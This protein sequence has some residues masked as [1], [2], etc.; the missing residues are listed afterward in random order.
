MDELIVHR[1]TAAKYL[2]ELVRIG[3]LTRHKIGKENYYLNDALYVLLQN[4]GAKL[5]AKP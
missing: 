5:E 1:N 4:V 3:L 2:D